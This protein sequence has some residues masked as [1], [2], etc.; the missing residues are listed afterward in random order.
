MQG[1]GARGGEFSL[2][3]GDIWEERVVKMGIIIG[4]GI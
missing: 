2:V 1:K 4:K 3:S